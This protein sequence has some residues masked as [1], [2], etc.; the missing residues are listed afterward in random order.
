MYLLK[1]K[2][3]F[4]WNLLGSEA[5]AVGRRGGAGSEMHAIEY[6]FKDDGLGFA[7]LAFSNIS[8]IGRA[9]TG[10][11]K[12]EGNVISTQSMKRTVPLTLPWDEALDIG[13]DAGTPMDDQ[14][15]QGAVQVHGQDRRAECFGRAAE[16]DAGGREEAGGRRTRRAGRQIAAGKRTDRSDPSGILL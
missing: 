13:S 5:R 11:L 8:G 2:P 7:T 15:Y 3:A 1:G 4:L 6:D 10:T 16:A 9:G 12:V 14:D